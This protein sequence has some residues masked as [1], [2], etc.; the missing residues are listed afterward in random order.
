MESKQFTREIYDQIQETVNKLP[1]EAVE[2][3]KKE[4]TRKGYDTTGYQYQFLVNVLNEV[5]GVNNWGYDFKIVKELTGQW[6][7]GGTFHEITLEMEVWILD[8]KRK[9]GGGHTSSSYFD[10]YK[11]AITNSIK[12]TLGMFGIGKKAF[13]GVLDEDYQPPSDI[14][15]YV[16]LNAPQVANL[17]PQATTAVAQQLPVATAVFGNCPN[18]GSALAKSKY[19]DDLYCTGYKAGC[20]FKKPMTDKKPVIQP[21]LAKVAPGVD[22]EPEIRLEDIPF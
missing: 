1:K 11:G 13:E 3:A 16:N 5:V 4:I 22:Q 14:V 18:C 2:H 10:A 17:K 8:S 19:N 6:P 9:A 12:K 15:Q 21:Q 20:K 7:K